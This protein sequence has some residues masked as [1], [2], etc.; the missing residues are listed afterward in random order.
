MSDPFHILDG[1]MDAPPAFEEAVR[2]AVARL[3]ETAARFEALQSGVPAERY[4]D[5]EW[6]VI[7]GAA[8]ELEEAVE[9]AEESYVAVLY[10]SHAWYRIMES[11]QRI[12]LRLQSAVGIMERAR[13]RAPG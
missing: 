10:D 13:D 2:E 1:D 4:T 5:E 11:L 12:T 8:A 9:R 6:R 7:E 3:D